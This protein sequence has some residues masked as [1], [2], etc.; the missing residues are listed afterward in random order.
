MTTA[1]VSAQNNPVAWPTI[2]LDP[3]QR[4]AAD[5]PEGPVFIMGGPG[6][7][8]THTMVGRMLSLLR[9]G[10]S[11]HSI[12]VLTFSARCADA[13]RKYLSSLKD[14]PPEAQ[15]VF[16]GTFHAYASAFLRQSGANTLGLSPNYTIWDHDEAFDIISSLVN[17]PEGTTVLGRTE[18]RN[19]LDWNSYNRSQPDDKKK[20]ADDNRWYRTIELYTLEKRSQNVLDF[21]D[22][23][24]FAIRALESNYQLRAAWSRLRT[25]HLLI[26]EFQDITHIQYRFL[27]L[28]TG[29]TMSI[30]V[31]TDPNQHIYAWRGADNRLIDQYL[32]DYRMTSKHILTVNH[33]A[34][35]AMSIVATTLNSSEN[36]A[37]ISPD[38]QQ[39]I[40]PNGPEPHLLLNDG[41]T[42]EL[43]EKTLDVVQS[44]VA[45]NQYQWEE[46]AFLYRHRASQS[47]LTTPL[48][49]RNIPYTI[50]GPQPRF[51]DPDTISI[52]NLLT[53][54]INPHDSTAFRK[55]AELSP[56]ARK[57]TLNPIMMKEILTLA[58]EQECN[59]IQATIQR[60]SSIKPTSAIFTNLRYIT[61]SWTI[62][63]ELLESPDQNLYRLCQESH[64]LLAQ[65]RPGKTTA[66]PNPQV[67]RLF[68]LSQA[69]VPSPNE[70]LSEQLTRF[71]E[72][73]TNAHNSEQRSLTNDDP[74][75]HHQGV[76]LSTIHAAKGL[77]WKAVFLVDA[78]DHVIPG[79]LP[80][81]DDVAL[82][83][84]QRLFYVAATRPTDRLYFA[85]ST[86]SDKGFVSRPSRFIDN[87]P[88]TVIEHLP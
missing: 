61:R 37:G 2:P 66:V 29:P 1:A 35:A 9:S 17:E 39:S 49:S 52:I 7:G 31:A 11:P 59:L 55:A 28:I 88:Q 42:H 47:R 20:P 74:F 3:L 25:R 73:I 27:R 15:Y 78:N 41:P 72:Q 75:E 44:L 77:Q 23:V 60:M 5:A 36:M 13:I 46:I 84:E 54:V 22:L 43:Y 12:V 87:L 86:E 6:T 48:S 63:K 38:Y 8:K 26:D 62:L 85:C 79:N 80:D 67:S 64:A 57:R 76:T 70:T 18:I 19:L 10:A 81:D 16:I 4:Q 71:L 65:A 21:D 24:P 33:R 51:R 40:R 53:A 58:R 14:L 82:K 45:E 34:T 30:T 68:T 83:E 50:L 32:L 56:T 69:F